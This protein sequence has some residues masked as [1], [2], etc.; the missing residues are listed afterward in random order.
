MQRQNRA[1]TD[2]KVLKPYVVELALSA[3]RDEVWDAL[4]QP[5]VLR[6]WFGWDYD[7]LEAEI[8]Q[9]FITEAELVAPEQMSWADGSSL[10]VSGDDDASVVKVMRDGD[11]PA[12]PAA[13]DA[14][15]EAWRAFLV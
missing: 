3:G 14:I 2:Q 15:E 4:T 5:P 1:V 13:Y 7:G 9:I 8:L 10:E 6:Q 12:D 11:G